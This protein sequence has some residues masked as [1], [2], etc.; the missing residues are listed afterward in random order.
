MIFD[1]F[2]HNPELY[3]EDLRPI[4]ASAIEKYGREEWMAAVL[5]TEIHGHLGI[6]AI[7]GVK[8]G[9]KALEYLKAEKGDVY[10]KSFAGLKPPVSCMNDGLQVS[11]G[12]TLGHGMIEAFYT[13]NPIPEAVFSTADDS[14]RIKLDDLVWNIIKGKINAAI[15]NSGHYPHYWDY[16]RKLAVRYWEEMDRNTIFEIIKNG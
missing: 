8:M 12:A 9:I 5:T 1:T 11:T 2:P 3:N 16:V 15:I 6:Y 13:D 14:V 4:V 10:I 7:I